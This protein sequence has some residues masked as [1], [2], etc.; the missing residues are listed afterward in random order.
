MPRVTVWVASGAAVLLSGC[1]PQPP[2]VLKVGLPLP[3]EPS[4][5]QDV[6]TNVQDWDRVAQKIADELSAS[7]IL[8]ARPG[9]NCN[10]PD[11][12]TLH[13]VFYVHVQQESAFLQQAT[14]ALEAEITCRG[15]AIATSPAGSYVIDLRVDVVR[16]GSRSTFQPDVLRREAVLNAS[17]V[18]GD[19]VLVAK[20]AFYIYDSDIPL[21]ENVPDAGEAFAGLA[22]PLRYSTQ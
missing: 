20:R 9:V 15:G 12:S 4:G 16:W 1:A 5:V 3:L 13:D 11:L 10:A 19:R 14:G 2:A 22:H 17:I 6:A 21:Y 8:P 7:G 18:L